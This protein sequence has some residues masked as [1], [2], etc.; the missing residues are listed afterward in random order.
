MSRKYLCLGLIWL[1]LLLL[2]SSCS[3]PTEQVPDGTLVLSKVGKA[4]IYA[5]WGGAKSIIITEKPVNSILVIIDN[6]ID[7]Q[8]SAYFYRGQWKLWTPPLEVG[9][10]TIVALD[11]GEG[12]SDTSNAGVFDIEIGTNIDIEIQPGGSVFVKTK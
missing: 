3:L 11:G 7:S 1:V 5:E 9:R 10:H 12:A 6:K 8:H 2:L 4:S